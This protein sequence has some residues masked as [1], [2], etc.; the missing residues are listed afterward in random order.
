MYAID[1]HLTPTHLLLSACLLLGT[2]LEAATISGTVKDPSGAAVSGAAV[3]AQ[4]LPRGAAFQ[5]T[6][7]TEGRFR[8][9]AP[10]G[11]Y[12]IKVNKD[13]FDPWEN[14]VAVSAKPT[15]LA[16]FL[17]LK[18]LTDS[19]TVS[20][21][22]SPL[23]N[24]DPNYV[25]LRGGKLTKLYHVNNLLL[26]RDV[27][28]FTFR[29]GSFSF[30]PPV[31]DH[32]A[33][34]VF[35]GEGHFQMK[36]ASPMAADHLR[37]ISGNNTVEEDFTAMVVYFSDAT[38]EEIREHSQ[39]AEDSAAHHEAAFKRVKE[40]LERRLE[41]PSPMS[42]GANPLTLL[43][44]L[45]N[46]EDVPNYEAEIL[47]E[48]YNPAERGSFR[49]FLHGKKH[50]D[51]RFLLNPSGAMPMLKAPEEIALLNFDPAS[52][53]DGIWYLS[54]RAAELQAGTASSTE[55]KRLIAP[56]H[57]QLDVYI[58]PKDLL[59]KQPDLA[60][61]CDLRF[62]S[63]AGG[64]R[65]VKF[66]LLPDLQV[67]RVVWNGKEIAFVQ[68]SRK[69][70]GSFY[71]QM[72]EALEKDRTYRIAFE[73]AGGAILESRDFRTPVPTRPN[74]YPI[75]PGAANRA[76]YDLKYH[77]PAGSTIVSV[78]KPAGETREGAFQAFEYTV[79]FPIELAAFRYLVDPFTKTATDETTHTE[80]AAY[81]MGGRGT[82]AQREAAPPGPGRSGAAPTR[83]PIQYSGTE[84]GYSLAP[85]GVGPAP[86]QAGL[87]PA[88]PAS[89]LI[90]AG[91]AERVFHFWF[92]PPSY[93]RLSVVVGVPGTADSL[94]GLVYAAGP[95]QI[96]Q[97][98]WGNT[99][100][101]ASFHDRWLSAGFANFS[102]AI[103]DLTARPALF[104][105][106]WQQ[107]QDDL[108]GT[109]T[110][111][112]VHCSPNPC[113]AATI[114]NAQQHMAR[115][116][117]LNE[118]GPVWMGL[119]ND[120]YQTRGSGAQVASRKGGFVLHMLRC[121]MWDPKS[122]DADFRDLMRDYIH[123]FANRAAST[124]DF[125][126]VVEQHMKPA[127]DLDGNHTMDWYFNEWIYGTD[128][129]S[130]NL[131]YTVARSEDGGA[132]LTGKLKQ[133]GVSAQFAMPVPIFGDFGG[134]EVRVGVIP[135][136]GNATG[137]FQVHLPEAPTRVMLNLD[138]DILTRHEEVKAGK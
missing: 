112:M 70:D 38:F 49:A 108:V 8:I 59:G 132:L 131:E 120:T 71:L 85:M 10:N 30:L 104:R 113:S 18:Q 69:Q 45:L 97:Q 73:Y 116:A 114:L 117:P 91:N 16:I 33:A 126:R 36:P 14:T 20:A 39:V 98:W 127:M 79:E 5:T 106:H 41:P 15:D 63:L 115:S 51:L 72:P 52:N 62:R 103:Y 119:L 37:R 93:D 76:T 125:K 22:R 9:D 95:A 81:V 31:L 118:S 53:S 82:A 2:S 122:G 102:A 43:Q 136:R 65:M 134:K 55:D 46:Y 88:S 4:R 23:A 99:V 67:S 26:Q 77:I 86:V 60:A 27:G 44:R 87:Q 111:P 19:V 32:V 83:E 48:L 47:A 61:T 135:M 96:A 101:P 74:W 80:L 84:G 35:V 56:E 12:S 94:P 25:S 66:D 13:G 50:P 42:R 28:T 29:S 64:T 68:E 121:M 138:Y 11:S 17:K 92:G 109:P 124:E 6:T 75:P 90:D 129:P 34:G 89:I 123:Q 57:Y 54:H 128:V 21:K 24:S 130:Y 110:A 3:A 100:S 7:D 40:V 58:R 105:E 78:G 1:G 133:S 107:A 137:E